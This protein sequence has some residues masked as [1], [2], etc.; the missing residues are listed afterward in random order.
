M[1]LK[2]AASPDR[3]Q[4]LACELQ[5]L[6]EEEDVQ[7]TDEVIDDGDNHDKFRQALKHTVERWRYVRAMGYCTYLCSVFISG[8]CTLRRAQN[9]TLPW[10]LDEDP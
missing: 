9:S 2:L 1:K 7:S 5:T 3:F 4:G 8:S 10:N 6:Q